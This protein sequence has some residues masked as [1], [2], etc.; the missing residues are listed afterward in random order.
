LCSHMGSRNLAGDEYLEEVRPVNESLNK[1][2]ASS[3][4]SPPTGLGT[5][6]LG[7]LIR[8]ISAAAA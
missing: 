7:D 5:R 8:G 4:L 1:V 2:F 6:K 3:G